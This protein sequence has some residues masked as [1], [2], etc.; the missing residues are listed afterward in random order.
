MFSEHSVLLDKAQE[1]L[2]EARAQGRSRVSAPPT[3]D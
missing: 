3:E 1:H 2:S